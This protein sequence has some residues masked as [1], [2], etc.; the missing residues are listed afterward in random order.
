[1]VAVRP[2]TEA[3]SLLRTSRMQGKPNRLGVILDRT[4]QELAAEILR[5]GIGQG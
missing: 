1:M 4:P 2:E 5:R 3:E